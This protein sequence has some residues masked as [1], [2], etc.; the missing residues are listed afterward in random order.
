VAFPV[1]AAGRSLKRSA[2]WRPRPSFWFLLPAAAILIVVFAG[3]MVFAFHASLTGWSLV[4]PG[5][6]RD[7]VGF[8]NYRDVLGSREY[9]RAVGVTLSYALTAVSLELVLG[10]CLALML[11]LDFFFCSVFRS[12]MVIP[13]VI[14]PAVIGI[15]WKLLYED[16]SGIYNYFLN[17]LGLPSVSWL[18]LSMS[19][20]SIIIMDVWQ[21]TPFF[22][23]V[24][25]AGLQS[26][27]EN[28]L[29]AAEV[30]GASAAQTFRYITLPFLV[31]YMLI[32]AAFRII[33]SMG[34]FDKIY[35][36]T[37]G[38][39]GDVTTTISIFAYKTGFNAFD[40]G[41]TAAIAWITVGIVLAVS[42]PLL[43]YLFKATLAERH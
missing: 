29:A 17:S 14:T 36:L 9:W 20:P 12:L 43:R 3:P 33:S 34:D 21:T 10:T 32:A 11:N 25:L 31:P 5:S 28:V 37:S 42:A 15:F 26:I 18:G 13:M 22:M 27:D 6:E 38:G 35:L 19:L 2:P 24:I 23:L 30:D 40:I 4:Q 41:R 1:P 7:F 39:P 8:D 16:R